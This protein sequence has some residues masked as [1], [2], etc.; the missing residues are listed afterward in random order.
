MGIGIVEY[1]AQIGQFYGRTQRP[2][3]LKLFSY[4]ELIT[5]ISLLLLKKSGDIEPNPGPSIN[6]SSITTSINELHDAIKQKFSVVHLNDAE[7][8]TQNGYHPSGTIAL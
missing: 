4:F 7:Y 8:T 5:W 1:R 2:K 6:D 3:G